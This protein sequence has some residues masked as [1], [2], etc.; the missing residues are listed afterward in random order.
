[1]M[2][3]KKMSYVTMNV[4]VTLFVASIV[5]T[6]L[7][8]PLQAPPQPVKVEPVSAEAVKVTTVP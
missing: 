5:T 4:A 6:Q 8:V 2:T 7:A 3:G 1:M